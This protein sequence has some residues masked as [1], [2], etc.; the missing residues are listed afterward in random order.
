MAKS[1]YSD[2]ASAREV[3]HS[4]EV[5]LAATGI[6][7]QVFENFLMTRAACFGCKSKEKATTMHFELPNKTLHMHF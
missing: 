6:G 3:A 5:P 4:C 2:V 7:T 1:G